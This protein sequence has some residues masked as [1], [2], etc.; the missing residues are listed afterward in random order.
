MGVMLSTE[1]R[2]DE[3]ASRYPLNE[4]AEALL[5]LEPSF[6]EAVWD[7]VPIDEDKRRTMSDSESDSDAE[8]G[9]LLALE[10]TNDDVDMVE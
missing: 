5:G 7:D 10:G 8:E 4:H 9:D 2:L 6:V 1:E 3:I